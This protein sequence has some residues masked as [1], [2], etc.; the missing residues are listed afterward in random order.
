M[1]RHI[2]RILLFMILVLIVGM[3]GCKPEPIVLGFVG[4][5]S[6]RYS[7]LGV[8]SRDGMVLAVDDINRNGGVDGRPVEVLIRN[9]E[10]DTELCARQILELK[11][12]GVAAIIGP[13]T[14]NM[15]PAIREG[16]AHGAFIV[17]PTVS[18]D[19]L[20]G[21]DDLFFRSISATGAQGQT[22]AG[23]MRQ[24]GILSVQILYDSSNAQYTEEVMSSFSSAFA[25]DRHTI[26]GEHGFHGSHKTQLVSAVR[27]T[28][29]DL[30]E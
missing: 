2:L 21:L 13:L 6:G 16:L 27:Q 8:S 9:D 1:S 3:T 17:S 22:A 26:L 29:E 4:T 23:L 14:S 18:T 5:L 15:E 25:D 19:K 24:D 12:L 30:P 7:Q 11:K 20:T 10:G 28:L